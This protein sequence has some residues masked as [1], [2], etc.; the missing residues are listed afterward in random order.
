MENESVEDD[1][2]EG[3][4]VNGEGIVDTLQTGARHI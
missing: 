2:E 4:N 3:E 1:E